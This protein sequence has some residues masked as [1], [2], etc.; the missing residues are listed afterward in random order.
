MGTRSLTCVHSNGGYVFANW[1]HSDGNPAELGLR[2]LAFVRELDELKLAAALRDRVSFL[3]EDDDETEPTLLGEK[4]FEVL[5]AIQASDAGD[6]FA[7]DNSLSFAGDS[8]FNE[9][10]Y[11]LDLDSRTF[12]V[13]KGLNKRPLKP[14]ERFHDVPVDE[15]SADTYYQV[16]LLQRWS[17]DALPTDDELCGLESVGGV[18]PGPSA[19]RS[20]VS[21]NS[22]Q[23]VLF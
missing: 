7:L 9:W 18:Q 12:E 11:V 14:G 1:Y 2:T 4:P 17:L 23:P 8:A 19:A 6:R 5:Q 20:T 3:P 22:I 13:Y 21:G 16:K 10:T 15:F